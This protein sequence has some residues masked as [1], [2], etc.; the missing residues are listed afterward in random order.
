MLILDTTS[1]TITAVLSAAP[2][3]NQP[4]Y[5]VAWADNNGTT[6]T[7]GA[8]DGTTN[9]TTTVTM[10]ASPAA[11]TRRV[12][13][14]IYI[15][16]TDTAQVTVTVG[17]YNGTNTRVIAKVILN[18]GDTWTTDAT[19]DL[20][21]Q[22]KYVFGS[23]NAATQ[24]T[25]TV[26]IANGGTGQSTQQAALTALAGTQT[27]GQY[28]R[29]NG[30]NTLL[31]AIQVA[32]VPTLNQNTTGTAAG[33]SSTLAIAS[34]G[35][36]STTLAGASIV[37]YTGSETLTNK[38]L[39][40]P[41]IST[42]SNTGTLTLPTST[43]T[44]VGRATTDTLTNKT[45]TSP[46]IGTIVNTGTL[47]LPTST[48]T[49]VGRATTDILTNKRVTPR[50]SPLS[51]T[52]TSPYQANSDSFDII[53]ITGLSNNLTFSAPSGTP[54]N[55]QKLIYRISDNGTVRTLDFTAFT[56]VGVTLPTA[57]IG[58]STKVIY[59]GCIYNA[60]NT[61]W[62]VIAVTTQA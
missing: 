21:G 42:I 30:T 18:V 57:T 15:Q 9:S 14:S 11:S 3:T 1:K 8:S 17:Y 5:V 49:L 2:A 59:V 48:D 24:L 28:L 53:V 55:G 45:L 23:V 10:V 38:T 4:N 33:L 47:T 44:L 37:T 31:S 13:K 26:Q 29:S 41:V 25:G 52:I 58:T 32:D 35:T 61:R 50:V 6:F 56:A 39:T 19:F 40:A 51:G 62:D 43:D 27:S 7:E 60:D 12:I 46:V 20:N 22:L 16:N 34:G 36:G 54:T